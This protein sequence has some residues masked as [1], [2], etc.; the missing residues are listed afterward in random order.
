M[1][2]DATMRHSRGID[3]LRSSAKFNARDAS[4]GTRECGGVGFSGVY[5]HGDRVQGN[6]EERRRWIGSRDGVVDIVGFNSRRT[7][8]RVCVSMSH[9]SRGDLRRTI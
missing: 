8:R 4:I 5:R 7:H 3:F 1:V 2:G 9:S 6:G